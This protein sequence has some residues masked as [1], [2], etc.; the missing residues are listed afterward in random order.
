MFVPV[1]TNMHMYTTRSCLLLP[2]HPSYIQY[3]YEYLY[4][5]SRFVR[6]GRAAPTYNTT[7]YNTTTTHAPHIRTSLA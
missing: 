5:L 6:G 7:T 3:H 4:I 2:C 1:Y